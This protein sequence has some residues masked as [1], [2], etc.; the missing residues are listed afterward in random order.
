LIERWKAGDFTLLVSST[1]LEE[2]IEKLLE[3]N[4]DSERTA[5]F[6]ITKALPFLWKVR[7]DLPPA[8]KP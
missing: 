3:K 8:E 5:D 7:G 2:L 1:L 6:Q 4:I